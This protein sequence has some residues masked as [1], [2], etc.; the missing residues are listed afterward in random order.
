MTDAVS[1]II[2]A[3]NCSET[4]LETVDS[5][6]NGNLSQNDEIVIVDDGSTDGTPDLLRTLA[7]KYDFLTAVSHAVNKGGAAARNTAVKRAR[8]DLIFCLDS[9]N[10]LVPGSVARL[11]KHMA[12]QGAD[13]AAFGELHYFKKATAEVTHKWVFKTG[14]TTLADCLAG[15]RVPISS[16]NYL[17]TRDSWHRADGYPEFAGA[18]DAWGFGFRQ[19]AA[20]CRLVV[21][22]DSF[23]FHRYGHESFWVRD[24]KDGGISDTA[25]QIM[26]P[27]LGLLQ[28][29][30][31]DYLLSCKGR[32]DW[33]EE[34]EQRPLHLVTG[35]K[36]S[37]G[38]SVECLAPSH[39][40]LA[41]RS[42]QGLLG[43]LISKFR[44]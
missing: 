40:D 5:I 34:L 20:G 11:K 3:Y 32:K 9:D 19:L 2:P 36:G 1:F 17:Y 21:M 35:V 16:G 42:K 27:H 33:F 37:A 14:E 43:A 26:M 44:F 8:N 39:E 30:D 7:M 10:V 24:S 12:E 22:P 23:Y 25:L 28:Q 4:L 38:R 13:V 6:I 15:T 41:P 31:I 18:L 29:A